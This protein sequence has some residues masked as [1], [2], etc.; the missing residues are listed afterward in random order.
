[1]DLSLDQNKKTKE[2]KEQYM[3]RHDFH[4]IRCDERNL[5]S[6]AYEMTGKELE[7]AFYIKRST[8]LKIK[9]N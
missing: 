4:I 9:K 6:N 8:T 1:L 2:G 5:I 7:W 3:V